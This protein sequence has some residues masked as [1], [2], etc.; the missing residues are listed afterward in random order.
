MK[1][2]RLN[3][4]SI[5]KIIEDFAKKLVIDLR[6]SLKNKGVVGGGGQE[7][8]LGASIKYDLT[9]PKGDLKMDLSMND[10]GR[11]VD[12]GRGATNSGSK[13]GKVKG[14]IER[15]VRLRPEIFKKDRPEKLKNMPENKYIKLVAFFIARK[16]HKQGY[17][18]NHF[19]TEV[20][21]DGRQEILAQK[22]RQEYG[23]VIKN[24]LDTWQ[25]Q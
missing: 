12:A 21:N 2:G 23:K 5:N 9:Y 20:I 25:S 15:W 24:N 8:K 17:K 6:A 3:L 1:L 11:Y 19:F 22:I 18:G 14:K 16:I 10:Y 7:S 13:P 4:E